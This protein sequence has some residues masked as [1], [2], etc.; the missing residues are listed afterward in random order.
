M[1]NI[2][3]K[4]KW[5]CPGSLQIHS[6]QGQDCRNYICRKSD[7]TRQHTTIPQVACPRGSGR[8]ALCALQ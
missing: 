2:Q 4:K 3:G 7:E 8:R 1:G 6:A 5:L